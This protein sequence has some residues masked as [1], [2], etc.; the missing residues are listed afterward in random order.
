MQIESVQRQFTRMIDTSGILPYRERLEKLKLTTLLE[1]RMSDDLIETFRITSPCDIVSYGKQLYNVSRS[2]MK[3]KYTR[4][5]TQLLYS[6]FLP[7]RVLVYWNKIPG[8]VK[9]AE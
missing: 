1:R 8:E 7:N 9:S 6:D 2:G 4:R 5:S 3:L